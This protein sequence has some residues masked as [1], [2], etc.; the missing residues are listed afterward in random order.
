M[1]LN[2]LKNWSKALHDEIH[3]HSTMTIMLRTQ[4]HEDACIHLHIAMYEWP[5]IEAVSVK[6]QVRQGQ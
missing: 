3:K 1:M 2:T 4:R 5:G 6:R